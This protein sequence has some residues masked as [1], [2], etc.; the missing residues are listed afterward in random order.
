VPAEAEEEGVGVPGPELVAARLAALRTGLARAATAAERVPV[1]GQLLVTAAGL[2]ERGGR[3]ADR[4]RPLLSEVL[5][6]VRATEAQLSPRDEA[7]V[8]VLCLEAAACLLRDDTAGPVTDLDNAIACLRRLRAALPADAEA[9]PHIDGQLVSAL[10]TRLDRP[11][12]RLADLDEAGTVLTG[13]LDRMAP[14]DPAR[15]QVTRALALQRASRFAAFGGTEADRA[16][17]LAYATQCLRMPGAADLPDEA[18]ATGHFVIAMLTL[19]RRRSSEQR[20]LLLRRPEIEDTRR[21]GGFA[22]LLGKLGPL[23]IPPEDAEAALGHLRQAARKGA[24]GGQLGPMVSILRTM[25]LMALAIARGPQAVELA[26][27]DIRSLTEELERG[28][29]RAPRDATELLFLRGSLLGLQSE[30]AGDAGLRA[31]ATEALAEAATRLP[32]GHPARLAGLNLLKVMMQRQ[33]GDVDAANDVAP[34]AERLLESLSRLSPGDPDDASLVATVSM[35][36]LGLGSTHR[37]MLDDERASA[38]LELALTGMAQ[39][40]P[41]REIAEYLHLAWTGIRVARWQQ[42]E[43]VDTVIARMKE[44]AATVPDGHPTH[45]L[46]LYSVA[47]ALADRHVMGGEI[48]HLTQ[49]AE[50]LAKAFGSVQPDGLFAEGKPGHALLLSHRGYQELMW[51]QY[52]Y[53]NPSRLDRAIADLERAAA[54]SVD[55]PLWPFVAPGLEVARVMREVLAGGLD[56]EVVVTPAMRAAFDRLLS[57]AGR[58]TGDHPLYPVLV[59]GA[60]DG[61]GLLG[62]VDDDPGL[63]ARSVAM[64]GDAC[65]VPGLAPRERPRLLRLHGSA[66]LTRYLRHRVPQD[67]SNALDRLQEARRAVEQEAGSPYAAD[68]LKALAH[69]Y[70]VKADAGLGGVDQ[71]VGYGLAGLREDVGD[72]LLQDSDDNALHV[73]RRGAGDA[74]EIARWCLYHGRDAAAIGALELG[75]GMV[76]HAATAAARVADALR[77]AGHADLAQRW[78]DKSGRGGPDPDLRYQA[79]LAL[80]QSPAEAR[81]LS[82]PLVSDIADALAERGADALAYLLPGDAYG[83][84]QA[85]LVDQARNVRMVRLPRLLADDRGPAARFARARREADL[86]ALRAAAARSRESILSQE[87]REATAAAAA[88]ASAWEDALRAV[89][90]WAWRAAIGPVLRAIPERGDGTDRRVVLIPVGE[91]GLV[92]WHAARQPGTGKFACEHAV[93]CYASSA[94]QFIDAVR[95]EPRPWGQAPV[96]V[97]DSA[98]SMR[99]TA[100]GIRHLFAEHYPAAAVF[101]YARAPSGRATDRLPGSVPGSA[102]ATARDVLAALPAAGSTGASLLHF[103]C[104]GQAEVPVLRSRLDL[105]AG[106]QLLVADILGQAR[107]WRSAPHAQS[108]ACGLVVLAS[109]LS[110][111]ADAD[112]DE[113]LTLATAFL[114]AGAGGVVAAR[115]RVAENATALL[116]AAFHGYLSDGLDPASALCQ[117]QRWMLTSR[118]DVPHGLPRELREEAELAAGPDGPDL[119]SPVAWAG[120]AYQG[121]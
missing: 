9:R 18:A 66:L 34:E 51:L 86:A 94:R 107:A 101:G 97:S 121:R 33:V 45:T 13:S 102:A 64:L 21:D 104:H 109:C 10:F 106:G 82:P 95:T 113:A 26:A 5:G 75:R 29:E 69:A 17:G 110:D 119:A 78:T 115:W 67:L 41:L 73:A 6:H 77:Q 2:A 36:L 99:L 92:P 90:Q 108:G 62:S 48:R 74:F 40:D 57:E 22:A 11:G 44:H 4:A 80:E 37:S 38:E 87:A 23:E 103:G 7:Q 27:D 8:A 76:L 20:A 15:R 55:S 84:G 60:A 71:A 98:R 91:L 63:L 85:V 47:A 89:C 19:F 31:R 114:S 53:N 72:V 24:D 39:D 116:M 49:A 42:P 83:W 25:A 65:S 28:A 3:A 120:F 105:G 46:M 100:A 54:L 32:L 35:G 96:L 117:A 79:M 111:V 68:V 30:A 43:A 14:E 59:A 70:R 12:A 118:R 52:G 56:R 81:L 16:E 93:F 1:L 50:Y 58:V 61:L 88:C 112:Y